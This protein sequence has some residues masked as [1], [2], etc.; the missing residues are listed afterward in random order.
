MQEL[1]ILLSFVFV[2]VTEFLLQLEVAITA[3]LTKAILKKVTLVH[4][5]KSKTNELS[6]LLCSMNAP[7][8]VELEGET[9]PLEVIDLFVLF[10]IQ[11][12]RHCHI[13]AFPIH[14]DYFLSN[15]LIYGSDTI[16]P[17]LKY[18]K[19]FIKKLPFYYIIDLLH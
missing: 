2:I 3:K 1:L 18:R 4:P 12:L 10:T 14:Y 5:I 13:I 7:V 6:L 15:F 9:D 16:C 17:H 8:M 11:Y 19:C